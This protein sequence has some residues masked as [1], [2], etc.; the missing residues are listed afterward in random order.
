MG[1]GGGK[2][3]FVKVLIFLEGYQGLRLGRVKFATIKINTLTVKIPKMINRILVLFVLLGNFASTGLGQEQKI[4]PLGDYQ[5]IRKSKFGQGGQYKI[6]FWDSLTNT[7]KKTVDAGALNPYLTLPGKIVNKIKDFDTPVFKISVKQKRFGKFD[8]FSEKYNPIIPKDTENVYLQSKYAISSNNRSY[9]VIT[10]MLLTTN[11]SGRIIA[12]HTCIRVLDR[13]GSIKYAVDNLDTD[14]FGAEI[15]KDGRFLFFSTGGDY[16]E[17]TVSNLPLN[18]LS[19]YDFE[20]NKV[21]Y[22]CDQPDING[23]SIIDGTLL[24]ISSINIAQK[25]D[26]YIIYDFYTKKRYEKDISFEQ[27]KYLKSINSK[28]FVFYNKD[29]GI[30]TTIDINNEFSNKKIDEQ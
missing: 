25:F 14:C 26:K 7:C 1:K 8:F 16:G 28:E 6:E 10:Y 30:K 5:Y 19:V 3:F 23:F 29:S 2:E 20:E 11:I 17:G 9:I 22:N 27:L 18:G 24:M 13:A 15:T 12:S 4:S 21:I